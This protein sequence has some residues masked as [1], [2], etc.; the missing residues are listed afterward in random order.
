M[1]AI[2]GTKRVSFNTAPGS[3]F[4]DRRPQEDDNYRFNKAYNILSVLNPG[5]MNN[6][7]DFVL[8]SGTVSPGKR[9]MQ[10]FEKEF[11][12]IFKKY[13]IGTKDLPW[14]DLASIAEKTRRANQQPP[15]NYAA[16]F[17]K[18]VMEASANN[19]LNT[20]VS[21]FDNILKADPD[22]PASK[23]SLILARLSDW[24]NTGSP[25]AKNGLLEVISTLGNI[26]VEVSRSVN[27]T[28]TANPFRVTG[29][30]QQDIT[31]E[32]SAQKLAMRPQSAKQFQKPSYDTVNIGSV[33]GGPPLPAANRPS[34]GSMSNR[35]SRASHSIM[36]KSVEHVHIPNDYSTDYEERIMH[37]NCGKRLTRPRSHSHCYHD[38]IPYM[39]KTPYLAKTSRYT[40]LTREEVRM[41]K[42]GEILH[43][44][45]RHEY[46]HINVKQY[47]L[48]SIQDL[49]ASKDKQRAES[50]KKA[51]RNKV[52]EEM[53]DKI[54]LINGRAK[55]FTYTTPENPPFKSGITG[56][57]KPKPVIKPEER[58]RRSKS[59]TNRNQ[60]PGDE[61]PNDVPVSLFFLEKYKEKQKEERRKKKEQAALEKQEN[62]KK[63]AEKRAKIAEMAVSKAGLDPSQYGAGK[64]AAEEL[65][66]K[67]LEDQNKKLIQLRLKKLEEE[68]KLALQKCKKEPGPPPNF[69]YKFI[70]ALDPPKNE[71]AQIPKQ[72]QDFKRTEEKARANREASEEYQRLLNIQKEQRQEGSVRPTSTSPP[73]NRESVPQQ[74]KAIISSPVVTPA[75]EIRQRSTLLP[76]EQTLLK[77][78]HQ[79]IQQ[80]RD[81]VVI[82]H[83]ADQHVKED[84]RSFNDHLVLDPQEAYENNYFGLRANPNYVAPTQQ[85][86]HPM[87]GPPK[88]GTRQQQGGRE[89]SQENRH[90]LPNG[91][92][93]VM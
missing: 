72:E 45:Y 31:P 20:L 10:Q 79:S 39:H 75:L 68:K 69:N 59:A 55:T 32:N 38:Q 58:I 6:L 15:P 92:K 19:E 74:P 77:E 78:I 25:E 44:H 4:G 16:L 3:P 52:I 21:R 29:F 53:N 76:A 60:S 91:R 14:E 93:L 41:L 83:E 88:K 27:A 56:A 9:E 66:K 42:E 85:Q 67:K 30:T 46:D 36:H 63:K 57:K 40:P 13:D 51:I 43:C 73:Q 12:G 18:L 90:G 86:L 49:K 61:R 48:K 35:S 87:S 8:Q 24:L 81:Y 17:P 23:R 65:K 2:S 28:S 70:T 62:L 50:A 64:F 80:G 7:L 37:T 11:G 5:E 34:R 26:R 84:R 89:T 47:I 71:V 82:P 22:I 33:V 1:E 54:R